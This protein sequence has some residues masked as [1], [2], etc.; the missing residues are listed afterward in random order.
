VFKANK[1]ADHIPLLIDIENLARESEEQF[2][3]PGADTTQNWPWIE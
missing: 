1:K 2:G 3:N